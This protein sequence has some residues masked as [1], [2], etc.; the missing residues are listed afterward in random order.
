[1]FRQSDRCLSTAIYI[2]AIF[3][4]YLMVILKMPSRRK[5]FG[6]FKYIILVYAEFIL[7]CWCCSK[8]VFVQSVIFRHYSTTTNNNNNTNTLLLLLLL[9]LILLILLTEQHY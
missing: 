6:V 4:Y 5:K 7:R 3:L 2:D 9:L 8:N 1:M